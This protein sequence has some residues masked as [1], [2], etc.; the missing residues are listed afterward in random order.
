[1]SKGFFVT[2]PLHIPPYDIDISN[3]YV[4]LQGEFTQWTV[5]GTGENPNVYKLRS[6]YYIYGSNTRGLPPLD[7][8]SIELTFETIPTANQLTTLLTAVKA[9]DRFTGKTLVDEE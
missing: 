9:L 7:R 8:D 6:T 3:A 2:E 4:S 1:M 5:I